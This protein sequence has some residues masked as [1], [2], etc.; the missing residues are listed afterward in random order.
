MPNKSRIL[1]VEDDPRLLDL[2][3]KLMKSAKY[4][5]DQADSGQSAYEKMK[6]GGYDLVLLDIILPEMNGMEILSKL[7]A[8]PPEN[9]N[10]KIV[11]LTN[12]SEN[13]TIAEALKHK[14]DGYLIKSRY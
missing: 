2:Y 4:E 12:V 8:N 6:Q 5:V 7:A 1:V 10:K 9:P 14:V 13:Q 3:V 11:M